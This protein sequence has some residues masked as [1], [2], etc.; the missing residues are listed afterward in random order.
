MQIEAE[1]L[2]ENLALEYVRQ[3]AL[4]GDNLMQARM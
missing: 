2:R 4:Y 3:H 1:I